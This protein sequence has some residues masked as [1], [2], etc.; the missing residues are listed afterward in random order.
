LTRSADARP[1]R[2]GQRSKAS[3]DR[4]LGDVSRAE[5]RRLNWALAAHARS[6]AALVRFQ[7]MEELFSSFCEAIVEHDAYALAWVGLAEDTP[8]RPIRRVGSAGAASGYLETLNLSWSADTPE[9]RGPS[10]RAIREG[11]PLLVR[12]TRKD[13]LFE[14][15]RE[16]A[17]RFSIRS[18][19]TVPFKRDGRVLGAIAVYASR[20]NAFGPRELRVF[21]E[22]GETLAF[23]TTIVEHR[24]KLE[25]AEAARR[26][27]EAAARASQAELA[28]VARFL[29][30][31]ELAASIAHEINQP[32][33][34]LTASSA[35][36]LHWL[37]GDPPNLARARSTLQR[38][39]EDA[40]RASS[41]I[42]GVRSALARGARAWTEID[43]NAML[44]EAAKF[45]EREC[46]EADVAVRFD[47]GADS[48]AVRGDR[49]ELQQVMLNLILNAIE[50]TK[51]VGDRP[52]Q[53][54]LST[55][56]T[57]LGEAMVAVED[58]GVGLDPALGERV[59]EPFYS[60]KADGMGL[61]LSIS[62]SIV[63]RHGGRISA[64]A[65][66]TPGAVVR[67]TL[68]SL[69]ACADAAPE[70]AS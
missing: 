41:I 40:K 52:R 26:V 3:A 39:A 37:D 27:A 30:L 1:E 18:S 54:R 22:L 9:G 24:V 28:R 25:A 35:A 62:R 68:P 49:V 2:A 23:A 46:A 66:A 48:P 5:L 4:R 43:L 59:F 56:R 53:I 65:T 60:T 29:S 19:V 61:G 20:P 13:P 69:A 11:V 34:A 36:A 16:S 51:A 57:P 15:W 33:A 67:F 45:A 14:T 55:G 38:I 31:G 12:D 70:P 58:N 6:S 10:G 8:G 63:E 64:A 44:V 47:L 32:L 50:A 17:E 7:S 21:A 42:G